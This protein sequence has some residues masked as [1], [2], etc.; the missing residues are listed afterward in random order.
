MKKITLF[1]FILFSLFSFSQENSSLSYGFESN[2]QYYLDDAKT[3]DFLESNRFRSNSFFKID[4]SYKNFYA[5]LQVESYQPKAL[6]N[7]SPNLDKTNL[8]LYYIGYK[9]KKIEFTLGHFYE[10]FGSG[11]ILRSWEDRQLGINNALRGGRIKF[12]PKEYL[13]FTGFYAKQRKGFAISKGNIVGFNSD[14]DFSSAFKFENSSFNAGFSY[15]GR[16]QERTETNFDYNNRTDLFSTRLEFTKDNFYSTLEYVAKGKDAVIIQNQIKNAKKGAALLA[17]FGYAKKGLG[18]NAT[19]RRMENMSIYSDREANGN[20]YNESVVNYLP[21]LTKQHDYLLTNIYVYQAQPQVSFQDPSLLKSGEIGGQL[22]VY[23]KLKKGTL[24]GG[25]YGT[26]IAINFSSWHGLKANYDFSGFDYET[27]FFSFGEKYFS[28]ISIEV[29]KKWSKQ[30]NSIF[31]YVNQSYNKR[32]IE[33]TFGK[34]NANI[35]VGEAT[36][37]MG[38]GKSLRF[39]AQFLAT[40]DD[41]KNWVGGTIEFNATS[42]LAVYINDIYNY[43]NDLVDEQI[44]YYNAGGSYTVGAHRF[45]LNYGRQRGGLICIGGV[46]RNVPESTGI[47]ANITMSF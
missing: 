24:L 39:E 37:K 46:C 42:K 36:Y 3:G 13:H 23:Y 29:R 10:Q 45:A 32:Y 19:F 2:S 11:L 44:H 7:Y 9:T 43:G 30:W 8:G 6:L 25:K 5:G 35:A 1:I 31:Y 26:K 41:K 15:V 17:N 20:I 4:Y 16:S 27:E 22:D 40:N 21:A 38:K 14:I 47:S 34:I 18:I 12:S 33:E 28:D